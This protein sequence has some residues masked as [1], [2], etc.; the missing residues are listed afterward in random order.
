[1]IWLAARSR[2]AVAGGK[3][4]GQ[5]GAEIGRL[6][7]AGEQGKESDGKYLHGS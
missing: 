2:F 3:P 5:K 4:S 7:G 6:G 1:M